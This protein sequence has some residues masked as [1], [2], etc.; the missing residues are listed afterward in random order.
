[1][2]KTALKGTYLGGGNP[3]ALKNEV[4]TCWKI[5]YDKENRVIINQQVNNFHIR[6]LF[7]IYA[8]LKEV[9]SPLQISATFLKNLS[10]GV[11][12]FLISEGVQA[13]QRLP[14]ETNHQG[15]QRLILVRNAAVEAEKNIRKIREAV[16]PAGRRSH[17]RT[18]M[19]IT[20]G[21]PSIKTSGL[22]SSFQYEM[23]NSMV[24]ETMEEY[25]LAS[26]EVAYENP[27]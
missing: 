11:W 14:T 13:T 26:A 18:F 25:A 16:Q 6:F 17:H 1:M 12:E 8:L 15:N 5:H 19:R 2:V 7:K 4:A 10:P 20:G 22:S 23:N 21:I 24:A 3:T 27:G 9:G